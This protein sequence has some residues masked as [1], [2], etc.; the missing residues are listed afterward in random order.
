M[1]V[2]T[3]AEKRS[4]TLAYQTVLGFTMKAPLS[5]P[6]G[7][8]MTRS[9]RITVVDAVQ[10][11]HGPRKARTLD[12]VEALGAGGRLAAGRPSPQHPAP[13]GTGSPPPRRCQGTAAG[14]LV[15]SAAGSS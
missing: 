8:I 13:V 9:G 2:V 11:A 5:I 6:G 12:A 7:R 3:E 15:S 10:A 14:P 1:S 4:N